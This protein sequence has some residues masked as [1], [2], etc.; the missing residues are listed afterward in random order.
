[1]GDPSAPVEPSEE[2]GALADLGVLLMGGSEPEPLCTTGFWVIHNAAVDNSC[3][4]SALTLMP[5]C[6][7]VD[8]FLSLSPSRWQVPWGSSCVHV[9]LC[10]VPK[11]WHLGLPKD[12]GRVR[13]SQGFLAQP[14][15]LP[16]WVSSSP[17]RAGKRAQLPCLFFCIWFLALSVVSAWFCSWMPDRVGRG[18][19]QLKGAH[20]RK[21]PVCKKNSSP[22]Q[23][24]HKEPD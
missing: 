11:A 13:S 24:G 7:F 12:C 1:M 10:C 6:S 5:R 8:W 20:G 21:G 23:W 3:T 2:T 15:K 22:S 4:P 9:I 14:E 18:G 17:E 16:L 19:A